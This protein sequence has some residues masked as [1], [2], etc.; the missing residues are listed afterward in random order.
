MFLVER[1]SDASHQE[2]MSELRQHCLRLNIEEEPTGGMVAAAMAEDETD[3]NL[4]NRDGRIRYEPEYRFMLT[5]HWSLFQGMLHSRYLATRLGVWREGGRRMLETLLVKMG[6]PL[7]QSMHDWSAMDPELK[8]SLAARLAR[9]APDFGLGTTDSLMYGS[10][11]REYG[12]V[13][14]MTASD[15]VYALMALLEA[16]N[17]PNEGPYLGDELSIQPSSAPLWIRNFYHA[18][19]A[20]D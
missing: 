17:S 19:D 7:V 11:V 10:Y 2:Q 1:S 13:M 5:R 16:P 4:I 15:A 9:H 14:R 20:L 8:G 6:I 12:Y 3:S 18:F